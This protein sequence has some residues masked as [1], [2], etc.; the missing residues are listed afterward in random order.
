MTL[1]LTS[2]LRAI[3][4]MATPVVLNLRQAVQAIEAS[5]AR[6][7]PP[8][9][10]PRL[11]ILRHIARAGSV[12]QTDIVRATGIDRSTLSALLEKMNKDRLVKVERGSGDPGDDAR[13]VTVWITAGGLR[14]LAA[15]ENCL[16]IAEKAVVG[17]MSRSDLD[18]AARFGEAARKVQAPSKRTRRVRHRL[19]AVG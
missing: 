8:T 6:Q 13:V 2:D 18:A 19:S 12:M 5:Y 11:A 10:L 3:A 9:T 15:A 16:F 7:K 14:V 17:E 1:R 4:N